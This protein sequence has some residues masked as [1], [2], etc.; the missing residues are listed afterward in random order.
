MYVI[1]SVADVEKTDS[2]NQTHGTIIKFD[3]SNSDTKE[4]IIKYLNSSRPKGDV[5][6]KGID[7]IIAL[8]YNINDGGNII[9]YNV[10]SKKRVVDQIVLAELPRIEPAPLVRGARAPDPTKSQGVNVLITL[11]E[12]IGTDEDKINDIFTTF[13]R[14][15]W[16][17]DKIKELVK[18]GKAENSDSVTG[19]QFFNNL[20]SNELPEGELED[21]IRYATETPSKAS[22]PSQTTPKKSKSSQSPPKQSDTKK[23][24]DDLRTIGDYEIVE[25]KSTNKDGII[26]HDIQKSDYC[27][28][29]SV[30]N[31]LANVIPGFK[32]EACQQIGSLSYSQVLTY[33]TKLLCSQEII[34]GNCGMVRRGGRRKRY[35]S[36]KKRKNKRNKTEKK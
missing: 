3:L 33:L 13:K 4:K 19:Q 23:V 12:I 15:P 24:T 27:G 31:L 32:I 36:F 35:K 17:I 21:I 8:T 2:R 34:F 11:Y 25:Q 14:K 10:N 16:A 20:N 22:E 5:S 29:H 7:N 6:Y 30:N 9:E 26:M 1:D 28:Y 18:E